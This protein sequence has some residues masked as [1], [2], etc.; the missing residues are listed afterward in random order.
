MLSFLY[1]IN[2][3]VNILEYQGFEEVD[4]I[5]CVEN[6]S[7]SNNLDRIKNFNDMLHN[8]EE[9]KFRYFQKCVEF[10]SKGLEF[11]YAMDLCEE[12]LLSIFKCIE[13]VS[14]SYSKNNIEFILE[15]NIKKH[16][17]QILEE[18]FKEQYNKNFHSAAFKSVKN[19]IFCLLNLKRKIKFCVSG[20][21]IEELMKIDEIDGLID[22]RN[23]ILAHA[24]L[25]EVD[26]EE[27]NSYFGKAIVLS[28][29]MIAKYFFNQSYSEVDLFIDYETY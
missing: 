6:L 16:F 22:F 24:N 4:V 27:L 28:R 8:F 11:H 7:S 13:M 1:S 25:K 17:D 19:T 18:T 3:G 23:S 9:R 29:E 2:I 5:D 15:K 12:A 21:K 20:L 14:T 26:Y 10:F